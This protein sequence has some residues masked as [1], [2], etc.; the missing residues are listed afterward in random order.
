MGVGTAVRQLQI[1]KKNTAEFRARWTADASALPH[2]LTSV[3]I[4][5]PVE[6]TPDASPSTKLYYDETKVQPV[7]CRGTGSWAPQAALRLL[8]GLSSCQSRTMLTSFLQPSIW[9]L[10]ICIRAQRAE[11]SSSLHAMLM[12]DIVAAPP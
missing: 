10:V 7:W 8:I 1:W 11:M 9:L 5:K 2:D 4:A 3:P 12:L 6:G